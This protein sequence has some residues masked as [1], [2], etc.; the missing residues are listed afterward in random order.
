MN[1]TM[2]WLGIHTLPQESHVLHLLTNQSSRNANFFTSNNNHLLSI[3][4][5][6][7]DDRRQPPKHVVPGVN[8]DALGADSRTRHHFWSCG[9]SLSLCEQLGFWK[10]T[11]LWERY[12]FVYEAFKLGLRWGFSRPINSSST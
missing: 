11:G 7:G 1:G 5:L 12:Q 9:Y 3:E 2:R 6:L 8:D 10:R 4:K